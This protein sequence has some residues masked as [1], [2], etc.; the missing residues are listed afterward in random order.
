MPY[1]AQRKADARA[2]Q[3][4]YAAQENARALTRF[5][6]DVKQWKYMAEHHPNWPQPAIPDEKYFVEEEFEQWWE[7]SERDPGPHDKFFMHTR[8]MQFPES[9]WNIGPAPNAQ[10]PVNNKRPVGK[11]DPGTGK[12]FYEHVGGPQWK[13]GTVW[14]DP[15]TDQ[16]FRLVQLQRESVFHQGHKPLKWGLIGVAD[17]KSVE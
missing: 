6:E 2:E 9:I 5:L 10:P 16:E 12:G 3:L 15:D 17:F 4:F 8:P 11:K 1:E 14:T 13:P 7:I